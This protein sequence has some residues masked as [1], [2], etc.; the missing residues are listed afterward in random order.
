M[1]RTRIP[2]PAR[3]AVIA[4]ATIPVLVA[5]AAWFLLSTGPGARLALALIDRLA[6]VQLSA[7]RVSGKFAG[8]LQLDSV[9]LVGEFG[10]VRIGRL[11]LEWSPT[12]LIARRLDIDSLYVRGLV[13]ALREPSDTDSSAAKRPVTDGIRLPFEIGIRRAVIEGASL[14]TSRGSVIERARVSLSGT[15]HDYRVAAAAVVPAPRQLD[16]HVTL[17]AHGDLEKLELQALNARSPVGRATLTGRVTWHP[18]VAWRVRLSADSVAPGGLMATPVDWPGSL[19]LRA[20]SRGRLTP[21]GPAGTATIDTLY[22]ALRGRPLAGR[23]LLSAEGRHLTLADVGLDWGSMRASASGTLADSLQLDVEIH[24]PDLGAVLPAASGALHV[25]ADVRGPRSAPRLVA[26]IS[27]GT[28]D[29]HDYTIDGLSALIDLDFDDPGTGEAVIEARRLSS[30]RLAITDFSLMGRGVRLTSEEARFTFTMDEVHAEV[31]GGTLRAEGWVTWQPRLAWDVSL[32][33]DDLS[34]GVLLPD[35]SGW[36]GALRANARSRGELHEDGIFMRATLDTLTGILRDRRVEG[37]AE[38]ELA[39]SSLKVSMLDLL[40][41]SATLTAAGGL[42]DELDLDLRL[43]VPDLSVALPDAGGSVVLSARLSGSRANP[44]VRGSLTGEEIRYAGFAIDSL[45]ARADLGVPSIQPEFELA[46]LGL[47]YRGYSLDVAELQGD[48]VR[49][50]GALAGLRL[51]R[52]QIGLLGGDVRGSGEVSWRPDLA[53]NLD[54]EGSDIGPGPLLPR[55]DRWPGQV[56]FRARAEGSALSDGSLSMDLDVDTLYGNLRNASLSGAANLRVRPDR[57]ALPRFA[58]E[59]G[60]AR[61]TATGTVGSELDLQ[62]SLDVPDLSET[63][64]GASGAIRVSGRLEGSRQAP[65]LTANLG[66]EE[67]RLDS[68]QLGRLRGDLNIDLRRS[69]SIR[70]DL[71]AERLVLGSRSFGRLSIEG[72]GT[73]EDHRLAASLIANDPR[74]ELVAEGGLSE[75]GWEG[76]IRKLDI[77]SDAVGGWTLR[78]PVPLRLSRDHVQIDEACMEADPASVC[79]GGAWSSAGAWRVRSS[80]DRMPLRMADPMLPAGWSL[81]GELTGQFDVEVGTRG[82]L[83]ATMDLSAMPGSLSYVLAGL[84]HRVTYEDARLRAQ[85]GP[86]GLEGELG[87]RLIDPASEQVGM[88]S[89]DVRMPEL[90]TVREPLT[91]QPLV[92]RVTA[93]LDDLRPIDATLDRISQLDG[94]LELDVT[95]EGTVA[96]PRLLGELRVRDGQASIPELGLNLRAVQFTATG[97]ARDTVQIRG[98]LASGPGRVTVS[99]TAP[100]VPRPETPLRLR[101]AGEGFQAVNMPEALVLL[102]PTLDISYD[103]ETIAANGMVRIDRAN[104][105]LREIPKSAVP[106]S[107]DVVLLGQKEDRPTRRLRTTGQIRIVLGDEVTFKGFGF[108]AELAGS[109]L[110]IEEPGKPTSASGELQIV[111]GSYRAY[112]QDLNI[113]RG[114]VLFGG[115]PADNPG[116]DV[117]AFRVAADSVIAGLLIQGTLKAPEVTLFS[118]PPMAES[119]ALS[120]LLL[121]RPLHEASGG[122]ASTLS[123]A[124]SSLGLRGG[125][126]LARQIATTFGLDEARIE[127]GR[128][129]RDASLVAGKYLSPRLYVAYGV[130]LFEHTSTFR[131]RYLLSSRWTLV[132]E[133]GDATSADLSYRLERGR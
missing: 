40:W 3:R 25:S 80:L 8:P 83:A 44:R 78:S 14:E 29:V 35:R 65:R 114:R 87:L 105:E 133:T 51:S 28:V 91:D 18:E 54:L 57:Y 38:V 92:S 5:S 41:G 122:D 77:V 30:S 130:G 70:L 124:A 111:D 95:V 50:G 39:G 1:S 9:R 60:E 66:A 58:L 68:L 16:V 59:W 17:S 94:T 100:L 123:Q 42:G 49:A 7:T 99:G 103:G 73:R 97:N 72:R 67:A 63:W 22:G 76:H 89:A 13:V 128:S 131:V 24:A 62:L 61:A 55:P 26:R 84:E 93:R 34:P 19:T 129:L 33:A 32:A 88:L 118:K 75:D 20:E 116:L 119:D 46:A 81:T 125:N 2:G 53:W 12:K 52:L 115:G 109:V 11:L 36:P 85:T 132:G 79:A 106:V 37:R 23:A 120:Y 117:R 64:P 45:T 104:I 112:G 126:A 102:S 27:S 15:S 4:L 56:A 82:E 113:E 48:G 121:G 21:T 74:V 96:R 43:H 98:E 86:G 90:S 31:L 47:S 101:I 107:N 110:A 10:D 71:S 127:R 6:P 69:G 108:D